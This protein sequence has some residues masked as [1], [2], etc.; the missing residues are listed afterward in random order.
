MQND[1]T[2]PHLA[3]LTSVPLHVSPQATAS[4]FCDL[5]DLLA[6]DEPCI[7]GNPNLGAPGARSDLRDEDGRLDFVK[8]KALFASPIDVADNQTPLSS[9]AMGSSMDSLPSQAADT[10]TSRNNSA[11]SR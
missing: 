10:G 8:I 3:S 7:T 9:M 11:V 2:Q 1:F 5:I 4:E 6:A